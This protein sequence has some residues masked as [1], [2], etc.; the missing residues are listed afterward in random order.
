LN[1]I[2]DIFD[3]NLDV[4]VT[5]ENGRNYIVVVGTPRNLLKLMEN[6]KSNFLSLGDPIVIVKKITKEIIKKVKN[7]VF[8]N[9]HLL[10][11]YGPEY[12]EMGRFDADLQQGLAWKRLGME[13]GS[14]A[15][16][17]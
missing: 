9:E 12:A 14:E 16:K 2:R 8:N 6:E 7:H 11:L 17:T 13:I 3:H 10:D 4:S 15:Y 5:L 1:N